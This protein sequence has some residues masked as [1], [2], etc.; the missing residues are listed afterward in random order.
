MSEVLTNPE[1]GYYTQ[2]GVGQ[3]RVARILSEPSRLGR[4]PRL[5][6]C[7]LPVCFVCPPHVHVPLAR[8]PAEGRVWNG[9]R[10]HHIAGD[11]SD[12]WGGA[13]G[14]G[15]RGR[16]A[17]AVCLPACRHACVRIPVPGPTRPASFPAPLCPAARRLAGPSAALCIRPHPTG[18]CSCSLWASGA[19]PPGSSWAAPRRCTSWSWGLAGVSRPGRR[20]IDRCISTG[21]RLAGS[22]LQASAGVAAQVE[23]Q[24]P[25]SRVP[26]CLPARQCEGLVRVLTTPPQPLSPCLQAR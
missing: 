24:H 7:L 23:R 10:L 26:A 4:P 3:S 25:V 1:H 5:S 9:R 13:S 12:V 2:V 17:Q 14:W 20:S 6:L 15:C 18:S 19:W 8:M 11:L 22:G 21:Y 16:R